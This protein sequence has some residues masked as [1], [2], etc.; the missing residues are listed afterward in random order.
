MPDDCNDCTA[1][2]DYRRTLELCERALAASQDKVDTLRAQLV[3][4]QRISGTVA[5]MTV[6]EVAKDCGVSVMTVYQ[7]RHRFED[8]PESIPGHSIALFE[9]SAIRE[10]LTRHPGLSKPP[11]RKR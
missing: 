9:R 5:G 10:F 7:W 8:W 6:R 2:E 4:L 11:K 1:L 3:R